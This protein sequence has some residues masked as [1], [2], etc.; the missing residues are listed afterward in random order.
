MSYVTLDEARVNSPTT[1][2]SSLITNVAT[3]I[4]VVELGVFA[5]APNVAVIG[6]GV[7]AET[8]RYTGKSSASGSGNLTGVTR[9][10]DT[11]GTYGAAKEWVSGTRI[12][13]GVTAE[14]HNKIRANFEQHQSDITTLQSD[15]TLVEGRATSLEGRMTTVESTV[16]TIGDTI[17]IDGGSA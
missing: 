3:T 2:L 13:N 7:D 6:F 8:I 11:S 16:S 10:Y 15:R 9:A 12:Y 1:T 17:V 14:R 5:D 4:P